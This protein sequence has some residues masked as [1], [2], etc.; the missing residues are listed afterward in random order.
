MNTK[1]SAAFPDQW[2]NWI[3]QVQN[4]FTSI[5]QL[6]TLVGMDEAERTMLRET[7]RKY[8]VAI[9]PY[10][11]SLLDFTD[12][13]DPLKKQCFPSYEEI[14]YPVASVD[15]PLGEE[16]DMVVPGL[17]HRYPDR[18]LMIVTNICA[19][20]CRH[21]TRKRLWESGRKG[22]VRKQVDEMFAY[23]RSTPAVRDVVVSGGDP[24]LLS[25]QN[26][27]YILRN[28]REISH[29]EIIRIGTRAPVVL[30]QRITGD[31]VSM[32]R[33]YRPIWLN[34]QFNH[35]RELTPR[36]I[37][38]CDRIVSSGIPMNN[39]SVLL[40]GINDDPQVMKTLCQKLLAASI[41]PYYIFQCDPVSGTEHLRTPV[42]KGIEIIE[43]M[44]GHT[45][46]LAVPTFVVDAL[47]GGGK[48]PLQPNYLISM[49]DDYLV[50][51]TYEGRIIRYA[52][53]DQRRL[54][55]K[56]A[57]RNLKEKRKGK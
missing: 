47:D 7:T 27:E 24:L 20:N 38:A 18:V 45:S 3:W 40:R 25:D 9:T 29:V 15:D 2:E 33:K 44:R 4:S 10:Y 5:D 51:R 17:V 8:P 55:L 48:I 12:P 50:F 34:T 35:P 53:P 43:N 42:W 57:N 21:C 1:L 6:A 26:L 41:R 39:Q 52:N 36:S 13:Q 54:P 16:G 56:T 46:G 23:I 30:P 14:S 32:L 22:F 31:L 11:W 37:Q 19:M 49:A 28:L